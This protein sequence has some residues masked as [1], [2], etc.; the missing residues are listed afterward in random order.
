MPAGGIWRAL[1]FSV[2][3]LA[4]AGTAGSIFAAMREAEPIVA[5]PGVTDERMLSATEPS[6]AGAPEMLD[7]HL[8]FR[9]RLRFLAGEHSGSLVS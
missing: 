2:A 1:A 6:L 4:V 9:F 3:A 5:G 7:T 8:P